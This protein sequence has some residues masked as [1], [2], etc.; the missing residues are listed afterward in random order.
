MLNMKPHHT[1]TLLYKFVNC[2]LFYEQLI[3][4]LNHEYATKLLIQS[5]A[6]QY[7]TDWLVVV[8]FK[9]DCLTGNLGLWVRCPSLRV[10]LKDPS[11]YLR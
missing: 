4:Y 1:A 7:S 5:K 9:A 11:P 10:F 6:F 3:K 2:G 8:G